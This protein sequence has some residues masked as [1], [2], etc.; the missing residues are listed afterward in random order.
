MVGKEFDMNTAAGGDGLE[1]LA[2]LR[3]FEILKTKRKPKPRQ[4]YLSAKYAKT[5]KK[6]KRKT[7]LFLIPL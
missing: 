6:G 7:K 4:E 3:R 5:R 2:Q 1:E